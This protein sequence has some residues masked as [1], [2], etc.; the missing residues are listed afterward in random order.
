MSNQGISSLL[1]QQFLGLEQVGYKIFD[2]FDHNLRHIYNPDVSSKDR[3][4]ITLNCKAKD[5]A[6]VRQTHSDIVRYVG[7]NYLCQ[8]G[9]AL[10]TSERQIVL[11]IKTADC[12]CLLLASTDSK[13][14][15]AVHL[16]WRGAASQL[17][18]N[19]V[20]LMRTFSHSQI[21]A[22]VC[23]CIRQSSYQVDQSFLE[24]FTTLKKASSQFFLRVNNRLYFDLPGFVKF[25]LA[26]FAISSV[27]DSQE[28]TYA[29]QRY[30]SFRFAKERSMIEDRRILSCIK[31]H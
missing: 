9:D 1:V 15:A 27:H 5:L 20:N 25:E 4:Y 16:G 14:V 3:K 31:I 10:V 2:S 29:N 18:Q 11:G 24:N 19:T 26:Q 23:P 28:N 22:M 30:F 7:Q 17:L 6:F 21:V 13:V 12:V 8:E